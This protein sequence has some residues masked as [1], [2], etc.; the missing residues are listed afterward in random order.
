MRETFKTKDLIKFLPMALFNHLEALSESKV[1]LIIKT[2]KQSFSLKDVLAKALTEEET[3]NDIKQAI[4]QI[5][6]LVDY[7]L[8]V[9]ELMKRQGLI[10]GEE[11]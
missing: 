9:Y 4:G 2:P 11:E 7:G 1:E 3:G 6:D 8:D 10:K 5:I